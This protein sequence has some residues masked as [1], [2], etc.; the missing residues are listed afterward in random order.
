MYCPKCNIAMLCPCVSC[1]PETSG[2]PGVFW[3]Y[4]NGALVCGN[5]H[6]SPESVFEGGDPVKWAFAGWDGIVLRQ[7]E[8]DKSWPEVIGA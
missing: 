3:K 2:Q 7:L 1:E 4:L 6:Y 8:K 5:C